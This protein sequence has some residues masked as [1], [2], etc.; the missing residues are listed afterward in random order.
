MLVDRNSG[1]RAAP[2]EP[3]KAEGRARRAR[4]G[5]PAGSA[6]P[7]TRERILDVAEFLFAAGGYDATSIRNVAA[8]A[9]VAIAVVTYHVGSKAELFDAV[10]KRRS[11]IMSEMRSSSLNDALESSGGAPLEVDV[12]ARAYV[13]PFLQFARTGDEGWRN[14]AV[15]MGRLS[16][17]PQG[18]DMINRYY[19]SVARRYLTE[20]HRALPDAP[21]EGVAVAFLGVVS[22]MLFV[23]ADTGRLEVL[24][25]DADASEQT[26]IEHVLAFCVSGLKG[27][28]AKPRRPAATSRKAVSGGP[29]APHRSRR[30]PR[31]SS[32]APGD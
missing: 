11:T 26:V 31:Q 21:V 23:C 20:L 22:L 30:Q 4:P 15:L 8:K 19:D 1:R 7:D 12:I 32:R 27:L 3:L 2:S 5:R 6:A 13:T 9:G 29:K 10:I 28:G 25:G 24:T 18:T 17:S 14:F 16:N